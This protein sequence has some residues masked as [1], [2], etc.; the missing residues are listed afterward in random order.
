MTAQRLI[1]DERAAE[2][3]GRIWSSASMAGPRRMFARCGAISLGLAAW[4]YEPAFSVSGDER[5]LAAY[6]RECGPRGPVDGW[7]EDQRE[8]NADE[9]DSDRGQS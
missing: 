6:I 5:L 9:A 4:G 3:A 1:S 7:N 2:I 8:V